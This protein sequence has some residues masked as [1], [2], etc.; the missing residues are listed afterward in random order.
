MLSSLLSSAFDRVRRP[1]VVVALAALVSGCTGGGLAAPPFVT[2]TPAPTPSPSPTPTPAP[3]HLYVG[4]ALT[5]G[6]LQAYVLPLTANSTAAFSIPPPVSGPVDG[7]AVDANG[8]VAAA[9]NA[10]TIRFFAA[11]LSGASLPA[12]TFR[13]G[14]G[15]TQDRHLAFTAAGDIF[16]ASGGT[17]FRF[18]TDDKVNFFAHPFTNASAP[19]SSITNAGL[20]PFGVTL[21]A[22]Q[23]LY[24]SSQDIIVPPTTTK[25]FVYS[26]PYTGPPTITPSVAGVGYRGVA[27]SATQLFVGAVQDPLL[28]V[29]RVD[30]YMLPL[31][32]AS[33]PAF[34]ITTGINQ[35]QAV[36]L[37]AAGNVYVGNSGTAT[38]TVYAPPFSATS[39][40]AVT[41]TVGAPNSF[42]IFA[43]AIG[44]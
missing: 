5:P 23:T 14:P 11:P 42:G 10:A 1:L 18:G 25:L 33:V 43:I 34:A 22:A 28:G 38:I 36:G 9:D 40:P 13:N 37:D 6:G 20:H 39:A 31:T 26:P 8:N 16:I 21:D 3:T 19:S 24:V 41:V 17:D 4:N 2:G 29:G 30:V 15:G 44:K 35:P 32:A 27:V 12:V 7:L